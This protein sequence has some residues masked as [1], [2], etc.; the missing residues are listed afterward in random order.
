MTA[1]VPLAVRI[2]WKQKLQKEK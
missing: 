2:S 1:I